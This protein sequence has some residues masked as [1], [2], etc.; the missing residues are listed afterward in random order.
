MNPDEVMLALWLDDEL[1]G[2]EHVAME[3]WALTQPEQLQARQALREWRE[4]M[5]RTLPAS[6]EPPFPDFFNSRIRQAIEESQVKPVTREKPLSRFKWP[7]WFAP[8][9]A[10]AGMALTFWVGTRVNAPQADEFAG[11]PRAIVVEPAL[12]TPETGVKAEWVASQNA[13]ASVVVLKGVAAIPDSFDLM[14]TAQ[15][16]SHDKNEATAFH[17]NSDL[18]GAGF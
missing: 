9:A 17:S 2:E 13:T 10:C 5:A 3:A 15:V 7:V 14:E 4:L 1:S 16:P 6:E 11:I 18:G 8:M 12:Y